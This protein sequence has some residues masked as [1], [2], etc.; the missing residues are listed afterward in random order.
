MDF[1]SIIGSVAGMLTTIAFVPQVI[2]TYKS[3]TAKDLSLAM[4]SIFCSGVCLWLVYGIIR[5]DWPIVATNVLT[6]ILSGILLYFKF[7]FKD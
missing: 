6:L 4:F 1:A 5:Q 7:T 2:K 3:K